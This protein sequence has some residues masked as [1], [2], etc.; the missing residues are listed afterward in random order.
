V[1]AVLE[2]DVE[3]GF[4]FGAETGLDAALTVLDGAVLGVAGLAPG[5]DLVADAAVVL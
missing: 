5:E 4:A 3:A 2:H 1:L